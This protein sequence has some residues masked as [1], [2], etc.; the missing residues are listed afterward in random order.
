VFFWWREVGLVTWP[1]LS[2]TV[3]HRAER[4]TAKHSLHRRRATAR[5]PRRRP[6]W[7][8]STAVTVLAREVG[9]RLLAAMR[10]VVA[11]RVAAVRP[12]RHPGGDAGGRGGGCSRR[13]SSA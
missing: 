3:P 13:V 10:R 9:V 6:P 5:S 2:S 7:G 11:D 12:P 8:T 4:R 1:W